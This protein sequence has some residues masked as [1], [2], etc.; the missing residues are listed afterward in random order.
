MLLRSTISG[1]KKFF[2]KTLKNFKFFFSPGYERLPKTPSHHNNHFSYSVPETSVKDMDNNN[3]QDLE[4][5]YTDF[6][7]QWD[8]EKEKAKRRSKKKAALLS[9]TKQENEV[10][11]NGPFISLSDASLAQKKNQVERREE[12][13]KQNNKRS[14]THQRGRQKDSSLN[15]MGV[16]EH[17]NCMVEQK[18]RE[19]EML[20]MSNVDHVLDIEEVL[21]YYSRLTCPA[22]LEI[23]DKFFMEMY[24]E[25]FG[26]A[27]PASP[28][29]VNS[30]LKLRYQ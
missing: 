15:Y 8:S 7:D 24:S 6:T 1:T 25:L 19:L 4:R 5:F 9:P 22:Y 13:D 16:R 20:D 21:H 10:Y 18:L 12:C 30:R 2:H 26:P 28:R 17:R 23:V 11:N 14:L 27:W 29:S 3:Y